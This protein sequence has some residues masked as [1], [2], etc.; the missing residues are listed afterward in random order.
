METSINGI[1]EKIKKEGVEKAEEE[2]AKILEDARR[3]SAKIVDAARKQAEDITA[4]ADRDAEKLK[5][6][7]ASAI[8]QSARDVVLGLREDITSLFD[9]IVKREVGG[10]LD[11]STVKR[12]LELLASKFAPGKSEEIEVMLSEKDKDELGKHFAAA[13]SG[14]MASGVTLVPSKEVT[15]GFRIGA[16]DSGVYYD[17]TDE[18]ISEALSSYLNKNLIAI[19]SGGKNN[20]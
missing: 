7:A 8:K 2:A 12:M 20:E 13:L 6:N 3:E 10:A 19:L 15:K 18:A 11:G 14:E 4:G 1:I 16:K 9:R 17:F 5:A